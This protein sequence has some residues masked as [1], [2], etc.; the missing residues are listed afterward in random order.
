[1]KAEGQIISQSRVE[2]WIK[3]AQQFV[4]NAG[5]KLPLTVREDGW[6]P[7]AAFVVEFQTHQTADDTVEWRTKVHHMEADQTK[8]WAGVEHDELCAWMIQHLG[9]EAEQLPAA[10]E[11]SEPQ[12]EVFSPAMEPIPQLIATIQREAVTTSS[13]E[14]SAKAQPSPGFSARYYRLLAKVQ[15]ATVGTTQSNHA[16]QAESLPEG[17]ELYH[18]LPGSVEQEDAVT[19]HALTAAAPQLTETS[20]RYERLLARVQGQEKAATTSPIIPA[21][22]QPPERM[23]RYERLIARVQEQ[24]RSAR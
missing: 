1:M 18:Q 16:I 12:P 4:D 14:P 17:R 15:E 8:M 10:A 2:S 3:Q 11:L 22:P 13:P 21:A 24:E 5:E 20:S 6:K 9:V 19:T 7:F 23:S